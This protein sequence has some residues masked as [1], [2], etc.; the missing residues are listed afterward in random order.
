MN[1][2]EL[3]SSVSKIAIGAFLITLI[4]VGYEVF[5]LMRRKKGVTEHHDENIVLPEFTSTVKEGTFSPVAVGT[6]QAQ[7][8]KVQSRKLSRPFLGMLLGL[9][10]LIVLGTGY[11]VYRRNQV[12]SVKV[13]DVSPLAQAR[14]TPTTQLI[15]TAVPLPTAVP[16]QL[17]TPTTATGSVTGSVTSI[18]TGTAV[19]PTSTTSTTGVTGTASVTGS[20]S[21]TSSPSSTTQ[22]TTTLPQAGSYQTTLII[23]VVS[24]AIIYLALLL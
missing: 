14:L 23:S 16:S 11:L 7:P 10:I 9:L 21:T 2:I 13:D 17:P 5:L 18:P 4:V 6:V 22:P 20:V 3:V 24:I 12:A 19:F 1:I 8:M 15:P